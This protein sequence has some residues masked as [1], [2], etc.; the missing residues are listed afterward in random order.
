M[1]KREETYLEAMQHYFWAW[2][3]SGQT[4]SIRNGNTIAYTAFVLEVLQSGFPNGLPRFGALLLAIIATNHQG[5]SDMLVV[6]KRINEAMAFTKKPFDFEETDKLLHLLYQLPAQYKSGEGRKRMLQ[7]LFFQSHKGLS[8]KKLPFVAAQLKVIAVGGRPPADASFNTYLVYDDFLVLEIL[9]RKFKSVDDILNAIANLPQ[10]EMEP[11]EM[12]STSQKPATDNFIESLCQDHIAYKVGSLVKSIWS[13][14]SIPY[15]YIQPGLQPLGGFADITNKGDF[16]QLL[17]SEHAHDELTFMSRLANNEALY[18]EREVPPEDHPHERIFLIDTSIRNWGVPKTVA[19]ALALAMENHPRNNYRCQTI[20]LGEEPKP[21]EMK[22]VDQVIE[23]QYSLSPQ[24]H[25]AQALEKYLRENSNAATRQV[26]FISSGD[27][28]RSEELNRVLQE[29]RH[30]I[31]YKMLLNST[32]AVSVY[33][34]RG[35]SQQHLQDF[36]IDL[37][38]QWAGKVP[39]AESV[40]SQHKSAHLY[41]FDAP[42]LLSVAG[43]FVKLIITDN[44]DHEY[45]AVTKQ[46]LFRFA[47]VLSGRYLKGYEFIGNCRSYGAHEV[48]R[49]TAGHVVQLSFSEHDKTIELI[50]HHLKTHISLDFKQFNRYWKSDLGHFVFFEDAFY[51]MQESGA[52]NGWKIALDGTVTENTLINYS[53]VQQRLAYYK[54]HKNSLY[55]NNNSAIR[56]LKT[57]GIDEKGHLVL[58]GHVLEL[59]ANSSHEYLV[60]RGS[61]MDLKQQNAA[62]VAPNH[63]AFTDGSEVFLNRKGFLVCK[64]AMKEIPVFYIPTILDMP[65]AFATDTLFWGNDYFES[66]PLYRVK[67]KVRDFAAM[68]TLLN[69]FGDFYSRNRVE[70]ALQNGLNYIDFQDEQKALKATKKLKSATYRCEIEVVNRTVNLTELRTESLSELAN[71]VYIPFI[72]NIRKHASHT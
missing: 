67:F 38:K 16:S 30:L 32:G 19:L 42:F 39:K 9:S 28:Y 21:Q 14:L 62:M 37:Q 56:K 66:T 46:G 45:F 40:S 63:F 10:V 43:I 71:E 18:M 68:V 41:D 23:A 44:N 1:K 35:K 61:K 29:Y 13:G 31:H 36:Q 4:I 5:A 64:S 50:N 53:H 60:L 54:N 51:H 20:L 25:V 34:L 49:S 22:T 15:H 70:Q 7:A 59:N 33:R 26:F 12:P 55:P 69:E 27:A 57:L 3:V 58:N 65:L 6:K 17:I 2:D 48:G 11:I 24:L 72:T 52:S 47:G 8:A